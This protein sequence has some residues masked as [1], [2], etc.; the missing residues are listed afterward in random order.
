MK[1]GNFVCFCKLLLFVCLFSHEYKNSPLS[2]MNSL[3]SCLC[4]KIVDIIHW[5][6][7]KE[8]SELYGKNTDTS[9]VALVGDV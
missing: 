7:A 6:G 5:M 4:L 9:S 3:V 1:A 8:L 2:I